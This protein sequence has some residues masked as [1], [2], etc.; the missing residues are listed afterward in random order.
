MTK[1]NAE[2][3]EE[4][5]REI[6][7][8]L[9]TYN[10][11]RLLGEALA[12]LRSVP[13]HPRVPVCGASPLTVSRAIWDEAWIAYAKKYGAS[14]NERQ[15]DRLLREGFYAQELD[16]LR[17]GWRPVE[18]RIAELERPPSGEMVMGLRVVVNPSVPA[19][20][21]W[22]TNAHG[23]RLGT[24]VNLSAAEAEGRKS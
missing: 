18:Q 7:N 14:R 22:I 17:P 11:K 24:I 8:G 4:I 16:E 23:K 10:T 19:D 5:E 6:A 1:T 12:A 20:E 9:L 15:H 2:L 3:A 21:V 13:E